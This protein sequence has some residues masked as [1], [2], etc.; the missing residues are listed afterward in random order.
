MALNCSGD[1][2]F[3]ISNRPT[4][5]S[6]AQVCAGSEQGF[7]VDI[8]D[9]SENQDLRGVIDDLTVENKRLK[10]LLLSQRHR[11]SRK[12]HNGEELFE[13]RM[14]GLEPAKK[15]ELEALLGKFA[16]TVHDK[17]RSTT[18][19]SAIKG[20][21]MQS[22]EPLLST[23][24][25]PPA[26]KHNPTDSGY[27]SISGIASGTPSNGYRSVQPLSRSKINKDVR[28]YLHDIPDFLLSRGPPAMSERK[29]M[30][31]VVRRLE[32]L[33]TGRNAVPGEHYQP[34]QQQEISKSA[35]QSDH[36]EDLKQN[37]K[38][39]SEG[40]REAHIYPY[41]A[42]INLDVAGASPEKET[43][44]KL[45]SKESSDGSNA[46]VATPGIS[47][48]HSPNQRPTRPLDLDTERSVIPSENIEYLRHLGLSSPRLDSAHEEDGRW[49]YLNLLVNMAQL[50]TLNVTPSF[51]RRAI[52]ELSTSFELSKDG[53]QVRWKGGL[54]ATK[55]LKDDETVL[56]TSNIVIPYL[57]DE[58]T[59][60]SKR[61]RTDSNSNVM[62]S[63]FSEDKPSRLES[64]DESKA[65]MSTSATSHSQRSTSRPTRTMSSLDY[66]P[67]VFR[68]NPYS[69]PRDSYL[70]SS[71]SYDDLSGFDSSGLVRAMTRSD[72]NKRHAD[73]GAITFYNNP[74]FFS[75]CSADAEPALSKLVPSA[76]FTD[77]EQ[78][79][80]V[81][82]TGEEG[83]SSLRSADACYFTPQFAE[84]GFGGVKFDDVNFPLSR[85]SFAGEDEAQP[86]ELPALGLG[87]VTPEDNFAVD[88]R[89]QRFKS[90]GP[91]AT[92]RGFT[93][94]VS[95]SVYAYKISYANR[96]DLRPA[97]LPSPSYLVLSTS[98]SSNTNDFMDVSDDDE[99]S[100]GNE[101]KHSAPPA[102]LR[103]LPPTSSSPGQVDSGH[104]LG[105]DNI[106]GDDDD[107]VDMLA[108]ARAV[109]PAE[110]VARE[111]EYLLTH[112]E[113]ANAEAGSL[114]VTVGEGTRSSSDGLSSDYDED[115]SA[116]STDE[117]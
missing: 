27:A 30:A 112:P 55:C 67:T 68:G 77:G 99:S 9:D 63:S 20:S 18:S 103:P 64:S 12:P 90:P 71:S 36:L 60:S 13:V 110:V 29:K 87:G 56:E 2:P 107:S 91:R 48:P 83:E 45:K 25:N 88:V 54:E 37:R 115:E 96:I 10:Q 58:R 50:H 4:Y 38:R 19:S 108:A 76:L 79:L 100:S 95:R 81:F 75:D 98:S 84:R 53:R 92:R 85:I 97:Q 8:R 42:N 61:S 52:Q 14:H 39:T 5:E 102:Y 72:L 23:G 89:I 44:A 51:I 82:P 57:G 17:T 104:V 117:E 32:Q 1:P 114:A 73:E 26:S 69:P 41:E 94:T 116:M 106:V 109:N 28:S 46:G 65:V 24:G 86:I 7:G 16:T 43:P 101:E 15:K 105:E 80:G 40:A 3:F 22:L 33:F 111:R 49:I 70:D 31:L 93:G 62:N 34:N 6:P 78:V 35:A 21:A 113:G 66:K 47:R 11:P 59:G 74:Y